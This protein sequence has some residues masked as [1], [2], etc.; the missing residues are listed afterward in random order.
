MLTAVIM[1]SITADTFNV[2]SFSPFGA[3][4]SCE[5]LSLKVR[6][7]LTVQRLLHSYLTDNGV[8]V[9]L[10]CPLRVWYM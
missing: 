3:C 9:S 1:H 7:H 4:L 2:H 8:S 10:R 5:A 6:K